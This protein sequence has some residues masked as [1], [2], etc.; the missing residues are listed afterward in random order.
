M[1]TNSV[2]TA[3]KTNVNNHNQSFDCQLTDTIWGKFGTYGLTIYKS[4]S[5]KEKHIN[6]WQSYLVTELN[7]KLKSMKFE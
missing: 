5:N 7:N 3:M 6:D 4:N 1:I 2:Y